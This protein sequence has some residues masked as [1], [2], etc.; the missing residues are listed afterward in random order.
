M[1]ITG[2]SFDLNSNG[3]S[4]AGN[5]LLGKSYPQCRC[6]AGRDRFT[7]ERIHGS[8]EQ[9]LFHSGGRWVCQSVY[10]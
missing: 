8:A 2:V 10:C 1:R 6:W 5:Y 9:E 4:S 7:C 3:R